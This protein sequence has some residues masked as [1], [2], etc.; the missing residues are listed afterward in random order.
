M[1]GWDLQDVQLKITVNFWKSC[2]LYWKNL[3][4]RVHQTDLMIWRIQLSQKS[5]KA[6]IWPKGTPQ[7]WE[8]KVRL[9]LD[10]NPNMTSSG[11]SILSKFNRTPKTLPLLY[12]AGSPR[13]VLFLSCIKKPRMKSRG[14][15][16]FG[17]NRWKLKLGFDRLASLDCSEAFVPALNVDPN[18]DKELEREKVTK[19][20]KT[21][22]SA[23]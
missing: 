2:S 13:D 14:W 11:P 5:Y 21:V 3:S 9:I 1:R 19:F 7:R 22:L 8:E 12:L 16:H 23:L 20:K 15:P 18:I 6:L 4:I 17:F 10:P